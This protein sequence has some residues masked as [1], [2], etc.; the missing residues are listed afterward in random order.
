VNIET[1]ESE[2]GN[3]SYCRMDESER[4]GDGSDFLG[5]I[6]SCPSHTIVLDREDITPEFFSLKTGIAGDLLQ[7]VSNYRKRLIILGDFSRV[8]NK[9]LRDFIYESNKTGHVVFAASIAGGVELL[10]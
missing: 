10:K 1:I 8:E 9:P 3:L 7:K 5:V 4:I 6:Y 2:K